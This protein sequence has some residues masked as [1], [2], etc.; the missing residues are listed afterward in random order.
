MLNV[1]HSRRTLALQVEHQQKAGKIRKK[2][3][4]KVP[5]QIP[6]N[7]LLKIFHQNISG[8]GKKN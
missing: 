1:L 6:G 4:R 5:N 8:L 3:N 2:E 7:A